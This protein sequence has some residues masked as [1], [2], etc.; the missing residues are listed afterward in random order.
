MLFKYADLLIFLNRVTADPRQ[1][2]TVL[3]ILIHFLLPTENFEQ[4]DSNAIPSCLY[5]IIIFKKP[6]IGSGTRGLLPPR[7]PTNNMF[8]ARPQEIRSYPHKTVYHNLRAL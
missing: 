2:D 1:H 3:L 8:D 4:Y 6:I 5:G 7:K